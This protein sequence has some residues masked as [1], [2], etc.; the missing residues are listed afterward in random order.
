MEIRKQER[1]VGNN[2]KMSFST[3]DYLPKRRRRLQD[4]EMWVDLEMKEVN[5]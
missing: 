3:S 2:Y 5:G 1:K 4:E